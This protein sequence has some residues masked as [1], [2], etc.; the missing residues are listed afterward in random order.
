MAAERRC[1]PP[2]STP[3]DKPVV[4]ERGGRDR[5]AVAGDVGAHAEDLPALGLG[6]DGGVDVRVVGGG[7]RVPGAV[8]VAVAEVAQRQA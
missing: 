6:D 7:D 1:S 4:L 5:G 3:T 2:A 8:E